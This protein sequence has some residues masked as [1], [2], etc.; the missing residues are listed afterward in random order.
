MYKASGG[1]NNAA[2]EEPGY[3]HPNSSYARE[4]M[5]PS[6][7]YDNAA[8]SDDHEHAKASCSETCREAI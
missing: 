2:V 1:N 4:A 8:I 6:K 3:I 7:T 5:N